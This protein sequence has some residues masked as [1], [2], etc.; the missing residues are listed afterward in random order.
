MLLAALLA[1]APPPPGVGDGQLTVP[2]PPPSPW[3]PLP[4]VPEGPDVPVS[5]HAWS[6]GPQ[7]GMVEGA[8]I[9]V[10]ELPEVQAVTDADGAFDLGPLPRGRLATF[11]LSH[12][13][14]APLRTGTFLLGWEGDGGDILDD[15]GFQAPDWTTY[16][17]MAQA[18]GVSADDDACQVAATVSRRGLE[19]SDS[20]TEGEPGATASLRPEADWDIGPVYFNLLNPTVIWPDP[21]LTETSHDGG[22]LWAN[23]PPGDYLAEA[24][25]DG[26]SFRS[27]RISCAP[28]VLV[29]ASPPW[30]LKVESGGLDPEDPGWEG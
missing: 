24:H 23:V 9:G 2:G 26:A 1:C 29:N 25:K 22:V 7:G 11:T 5:G 3:D 8:V 12:P 21:S 27:A 16:A 14:H 4:A 10:V 30:G 28:G 6:F 15:L 18:T 17:L 13:D 19:E 20:Q